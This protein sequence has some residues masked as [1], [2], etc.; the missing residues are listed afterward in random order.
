MPIRICIVVKITWIFELLGIANLLNNCVNDINVVFKRSIIFV[1]HNQGLPCRT[2]RLIFNHI[3]QHF[4]IFSKNLFY[5]ILILISYNK[6]SYCNLQ[7]WLH[8]CQNF[9]ATLLLLVKLSK[10][11]IETK[12]T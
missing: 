9:G 1:Q 12:Y 3:F 8:V 5:F 2:H 7:K 10:L 4:V 11:L 6:I